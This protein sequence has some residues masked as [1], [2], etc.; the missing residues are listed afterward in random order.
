MELTT[1]RIVGVIQIKIKT[2]IVETHYPVLLTQLI[3]VIYD[4]LNPKTVTKSL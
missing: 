4:Y 1:A 3:N 2:V